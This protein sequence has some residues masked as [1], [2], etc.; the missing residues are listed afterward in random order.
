M[1]TQGPRTPCAAGTY[2]ANQRTSACGARLGG[3]AAAQTHS[4]NAADDHRHAQPLAHAHAEGQHAEEVVGLAEV[5][6]DEAQHAVADEEHAGHLPRLRSLR[7]YSHSSDEQQQPFQQELVD[8]R[9][10]ARQHRA[11]LRKHHAPGQ[12]GAL[13]RPH[14][15]PLMKLPT[16][17]AA[18]PV[19]TQGATKSIT[20]QNGRRRECAQTTMRADHAQQPPWKLM[21]PCHT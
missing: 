8:L 16:R 18:R 15:S 10:V 13:K 5:L 14:S 11:A 4:S 3:G 20:C 1:R 2:P 6:G 12:V 9:G 17:P 19:G 7:A 21:P